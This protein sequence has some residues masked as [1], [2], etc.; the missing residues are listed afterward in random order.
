MC[1]LQ[2]WSPSSRFLLIVK[3]NCKPNSESILPKRLENDSATVHQ[4]RRTRREQC[5]RFGPVMLQKVKRDPP[6]FIQGDDLAVYE[7]N[8]REVFT[9]YQSG[10]NGWTGIALLV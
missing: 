6:V 3:V 8:G 7:G 2:F 4:A 9:T 1:F 5:L 10:L